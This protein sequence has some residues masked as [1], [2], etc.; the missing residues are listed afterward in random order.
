[1]VAILRDIDRYSDRFSK[2]E[3][4][5]PLE[6]E[7]PTAAELKSGIDPGAHG[8]TSARSIWRRSRTAASP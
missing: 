6:Q 1:M 4:V 5:F 3:A 2:S 7:D 8:I